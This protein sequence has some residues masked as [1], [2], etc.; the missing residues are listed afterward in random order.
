VTRE[1]LLIQYRLDLRTEALKATSQIR[2]TGSNPDPRSRTKFDHLRKLS[3]IERNSTGSAPLSTQI[4][5]R[6]GNSMWIEA[7]L[8]GRS[9]A[10]GA[11]IA[12]SLG[13]DTVTGS[14]AVDVTLG[15]DSSPRSKARRH[16]N[17][18]FAFT[19]CVLATS[20][21]LAPGS[22]VSSTIRRFSDTDLHRR[23][24]RSD[25]DPSACTMT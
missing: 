3:R 19:P 23:T 13:A 24:R 21:T 20:A 6:P 4:I 18:W 22:N 17:T 8:V 25:T 7:D 10:P 11:R 14:K 12:V 16:L 5:A 15:S 9:C 2:N 1:R